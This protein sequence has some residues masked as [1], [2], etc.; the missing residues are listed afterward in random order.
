MT[1]IDWHFIFVLEKN[2]ADQ[3][4]SILFFGFCTYIPLSSVIEVKVDLKIV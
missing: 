2:T 1:R 4:V 3:K